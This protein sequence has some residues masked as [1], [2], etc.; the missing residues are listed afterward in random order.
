MGLLAYTYGTNGIPLPKN[1]PY[2]VSLIDERP[3]F[4]TSAVFAKLVLIS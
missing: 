4:A 2:A 1:Q 3:S